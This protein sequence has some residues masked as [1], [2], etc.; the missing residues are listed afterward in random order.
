MPYDDFIKEFRA[1]TVAEIDDEASYVYK[2]TKDKELNG[3]YF[4]IDI[5]QEGV[6]SFH[7]DKTPERIYPEKYQEMFKYPEAIIEIGRI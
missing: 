6:Y 3:V 4:T 1:L 2:S 7:V 5:L